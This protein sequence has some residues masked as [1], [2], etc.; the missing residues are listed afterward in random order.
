MPA[1]YVEVQLR[2]SEEL[3][4][5]LVGILSQLGFEGFW[6][7]GTLLKCYIS[8]SRWTPALKEEVETTVI[9]MSRSIST[10]RPEVTVRTI[11]GRNWNE[12]W[13]KTIKP[14]HVTD[15]IVIKPT[16]QAYSFWTCR[17]AI[18]DPGRNASTP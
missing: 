4:E 11:D 5:Q 15:H 1:S 2:T 17:S 16:W 9:R 13:E 6:E 3:V 10:A 18:C 12:E 8:L 7:D 14:I